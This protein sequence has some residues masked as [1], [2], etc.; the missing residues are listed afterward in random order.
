MPNHCYTLQS[1]THKYQTMFL[2]R[3]T[4]TYYILQAVSLSPMLD[5]YMSYVFHILLVHSPRYISDILTAPFCPNQ[6]AIWNSDT[7]EFPLLLISSVCYSQYYSSVPLRRRHR[8][9]FSFLR[10][11]SNIA[12]HE[13]RRILHNHLKLLMFLKLNCIVF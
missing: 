11:F 12:F 5:F 4:F 10:K 1:F 2:Y 3:Y 13:R 7:L 8:V 6:I 9:Y